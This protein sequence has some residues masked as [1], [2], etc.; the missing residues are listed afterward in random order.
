MEKRTKGFDESI[1]FTFLILLL[2]DW[3]HGKHGRPDKT[4]AEELL[5]LILLL[6]IVDCY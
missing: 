6:L 4:F 2:F 5:L 3:G 1:I